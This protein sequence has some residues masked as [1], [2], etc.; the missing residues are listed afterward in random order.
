MLWALLLVLVCGGTRIRAEEADAL[1]DAPSAV[2]QQSAAPQDET[3]EQRKERLRAEAEREV[4]TEEKQRILAVV[5]NFNTVEN[6]QAVALTSGEKMRLAMRASIDP[7]TFVGATFLAGFSEVNDDDRGFGWGPGG[8]GKRVGA[9]YADEF[10]GI[11]F[12][13]AVYPILLHQDPR[14]FRKGKGRVVLRVK[15]AIL[16]SVICR[17]DNGRDQPNYSNVFGNLT[18]GVI[19]NAYYPSDERGVRLTLVNSATTIAG[20]ALG[21]I[22]LE[23]TPDIA[24]WW[25]QRK[26][27]RA[28]P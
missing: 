7:F 6:G 17:G 11:L 10:D 22:A 5:P 2:M 16:S 9:N 8:F 19:S 21:N 18:Q 15:H 24:Q 28:Q 26:T 12:A 14:Y 4:K 13:N 1:P 25:K 20:G 3:E 27:R 23:F